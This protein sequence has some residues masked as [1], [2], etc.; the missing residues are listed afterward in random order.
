MYYDKS[1]KRICWQSTKYVLVRDFKKNANQEQ[2]Q[3]K[4]E[5]KN[6][7]FNIYWPNTAFKDL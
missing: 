4:K 5:R 3:K 7:I 6:S 2:K 1:K